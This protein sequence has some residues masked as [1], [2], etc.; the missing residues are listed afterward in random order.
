MKNC[1]KCDHPHEKPG[2]YCSRKCANSR[3]WSEEDKKKKSE[4][5]KRFI[6]NNGGNLQEPRPK[7]DNCLNC[8][9]DIKVKNNIFFCSHNC[10]RQFE[11]KNNT[12][13]K[14][15]KMVEDELPMQ[16]W[17]VRLMITRTRPHICEICSITEWNNKP[18]TL[19]VDHID[20]NHKNNKQE[21]LRLIC[22][23]CHSQTD[24]YKN[25]NRGNGRNKMSLTKR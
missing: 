3:V 23:N 9:E 17:Q 11:W 24:T 18:I 13:P 14:Y 4:S 6:V 1:P 8:H 5:V 20:G 19:E 25:K 7:F 2:T 21:N 16:K 15:L 12:L 10:Y 22:P